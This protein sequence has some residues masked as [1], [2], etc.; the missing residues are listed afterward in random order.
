MKILFVKPSPFHEAVS[1]SLS[2]LGLSGVCLKEEQLAAVKGVYD[3][4]DV[5]TCQTIHGLSRDL[6][7]DRDP[8]I[9]TI[10]QGFCHELESV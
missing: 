5:H 8:G 6:G 10:I 3:G 7:S 2:R 4:Q 9:L 1:F